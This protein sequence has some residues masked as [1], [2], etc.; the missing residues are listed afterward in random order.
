MGAP[1]G[2]PPLLRCSSL[3]PSL[4]LWGWKQQR[5]ICCWLHAARCSGGPTLGCLWRASWWPFA[6]A[7]IALQ[8]AEQV[9]WGPTGTPSK[10]KE[11]FLLLGKQQQ[12]KEQQQHLLLLLLLLRLQ[13]VQHDVCGSSACCW[14]A[15]LLLA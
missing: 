9:V 13:Q 8:G 3:R 6:A 7:S 2:A 10:M 1:L 4:P 12:I 5:G 11:L 14:G 15:P